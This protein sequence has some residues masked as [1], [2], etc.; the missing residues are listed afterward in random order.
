MQLDLNASTYEEETLSDHYVLLNTLGRGAFGEVKL[1]YHLLTNLKVAVKILAN[2]EESDGNHRKE[3]N[4]MKELDHP[5]IIK[6]FHIINSKD[7]T[8]MVLE[9]AAHGDL[10]TLIE[11]GG[12]LQQTQAQQFFS[13]IV[14]AVHYCHDNDIAHR[15]IKLDNILLDD[16][17]NIK[18]CDFGM[19]VR[20]S[21]GQRCKEFC[22]TIEY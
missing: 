7:H 17:G 2:G 22:G 5:Y 16:K 21:A 13:Q 6:L 20:V 11:E 12:P 14:C 10:V 3:L 19:A 9:F 8:Y 15:D 1:A 18:L 4:F